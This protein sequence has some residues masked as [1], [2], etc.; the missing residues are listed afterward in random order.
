MLDAVSQQL[1][2]Y[3]DL[4]ATRQKLVAANI[5]NIDTPGYRT[6]DIDFQ[7]EFQD[8]LPGE[9]PKIVNV[10]NLKV[11]N[12]GNDVS[13]D[14]ES[15]M[16]AENDLR[17]RLAESLLKTKFSVIKMAIEGEKSS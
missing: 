9:K 4:V 1:E 15:R 7:T 14:R 5:A 12:D 2:K 16:L 6:Q 13:M 3:M 10:P 11:R 8:L 17:F